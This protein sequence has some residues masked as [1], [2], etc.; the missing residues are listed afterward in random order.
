MALYKSFVYQSDLVFQFNTG[1]NAASCADTCQAGYSD[2]TQRVPQI[3]QDSKQEPM[4]TLSVVLNAAL[5]CTHLG[6]QPC[7]GQ[8]GSQRVCAQVIQALTF[9]LVPYRMGIYEFTVFV[10]QK[11]FIFFTY[12]SSYSSQI[13]MYMI[14]HYMTH[15]IWCL[16]KLLKP[17]GYKTSSLLEK[18]FFM[19]KMIFPISLSYFNPLYSY[20]QFCYEN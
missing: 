2:V 5:A 10:L 20:E 19:N 18:T 17:L 14:T 13:Y 1:F 15:V 3:I 12:T 4:G 11:K 6:A 8:R 9:T 16:L 7:A